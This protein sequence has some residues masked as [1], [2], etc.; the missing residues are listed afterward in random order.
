MSKVNSSTSSSDHLEV[1]GG[2]ALFLIIRAVM[3]TVLLVGSVISAFAFWHQCTPTFSRAEDPQFVDALIA[4]Q[5]DR[6]ELITSA[7]FLIVGDSSGLMDISP[8]I[9]ASQLGRSVETLATIAY[10]GPRG[11]ASILDRVSTRRVHP[12]VIIL[13][14]HASGLSKL[15]EW[16]NWTDR[17]VHG[18][19]KPPAERNLLRG[20]LG[21]M[22]DLVSS[23]VYRPLEGAYGSYYGGVYDFESFIQGNHG[24]AIDPRPIE[25]DDDRLVSKLEWCCSFEISETFRSEIPE[26]RLALDKFPDVETLLL[27]SPLPQRWA[28]PQGVTNREAAIT[29]LLQELGLER[30]ALI[31]TPAYLPGSRFAVTTHLHESAVPQFT[32]LLA[33]ILRERK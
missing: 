26:L 19:P 6:A 24:G 1:T 18:P 13:V 31:K 14:A 12:K 22:N 30:T 33:D 21:K 3:P 16:S 20:A 2:A 28:T 8:G 10:A 23:T 17:V 5:I 15:K 11:I 9:L 27:V 4:A 29:E 25:N 32:R 7:D